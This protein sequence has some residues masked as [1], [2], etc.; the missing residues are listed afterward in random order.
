MRLPKFIFSHYFKCSCKQIEQRQKEKSVSGVR[1]TYEFLAITKVVRFQKC[2]YVCFFGCHWIKGFASLSQICL[3]WANGM[4]LGVCVCVYMCTFVEQNN[5]V[6]VYVCVCIKS[7]SYVT[8]FQI[9]FMFRSSQA[10]RSFKHKTTIQYRVD[11]DAIVLHT[12]KNSYWIAFFC[13][14]CCCFASKIEYFTKCRSE[15]TDYL[16]TKKCI[17]IILSFFRFV[18]MRFLCLSAITM[19]VTARETAIPCCESAEREK[20]TEKIVSAVPNLQNLPG[21]HFCKN[22][23][24][25]LAHCCW[26]DSHLIYA[27]N[28]HRLGQTMTIMGKIH[29]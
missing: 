21:N 1:R 24:T 26:T 2:S 22:A 8:K 6:F 20:K 5:R 11:P 27:Y 14:C 9:G 23:R 12:A 29:E 17:Y 3:C 15:F 16:L 10:N 13:S 25:K 28:N 19:V 18:F 7:M 4:S